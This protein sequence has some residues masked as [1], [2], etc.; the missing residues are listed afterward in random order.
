MQKTNGNHD[1]IYRLL[2]RLVAPFARG[3]FR[4]HHE[5][6]RFRGPTLVICNHVTNYDPI[7]VGISFPKDPLHFVCSEHL[8]RLGWISKVL[9]F[10]FDPIPRRKAVSGA[11][12][13]MAC[14]RKL[15]QG[16]SVC[17]FAE[18]K[19]TWDGI[20]AEIVPSTGRL[21][22]MSGVS[23]ITCRLEGAYLTAPRWGKGIRPGKM[24]F[25][26]VGTYS[27]E[28]L[29]TMDGQQIEE[30]IQRDIHE[31]IWESQ[32]A[33]PVRYRSRRRAENL[34]TVLY[35]CPRC[36]KAGNLT[37]K[38]KHLLCG[39]GAK[40]EYTEFGAFEPREPLE[41]IAQGDAWQRRELARQLQEGNVELQDEQ[42][43]VYSLGD[44]HQETVLTTDTLIL[45]D[46]VLRCG[47]LQWPLADI[48]ALALVQSRNLMLS[49]GE[50][51]Y[52][53]K[54]AKSCSL[55]KYRAAWKAVREQSQCEV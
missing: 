9:Q 21:A 15:K 7:L 29:Q 42:V 20:T 27:P 48:D 34:Q 22:R 37:S 54:A 3:I 43:T 19:C 38:G 32:K 46:G 11:D 13:A 14:L 47:H 51:Y 28:T 2:A 49:C 12:T 1:G 16:R 52:Q 50:G 45:Q 44:Q 6:H 8:F 53:L 10:V 41:N 17:L 31:N 18:G 26:V 5:K 23:L 30:L 4:F 40:W 33:Q 35:L 25:R 36:R 24:G 39:C 55:R